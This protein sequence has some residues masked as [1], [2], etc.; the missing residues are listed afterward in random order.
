MPHV[1]YLHSALTQ[2]R[3]VI[4]D[5]LLLKKL[6][7]FEMIDLVIAAKSLHT[8]L[9]ATSLTAEVSTCCPLHLVWREAA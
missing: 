9:T 8:I 4:S 5:P 3:I 6:L 2:G 7:R 1:I